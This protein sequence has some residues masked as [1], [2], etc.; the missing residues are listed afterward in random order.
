MA[1]KEVISELNKMASKVEGTERIAQVMFALCIVFICISCQ[2]AQQSGPS[3][4][5]YRAHGGC[6]F[7]YGEMFC[8]S[9]C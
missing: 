8:I 5:G 1:V 7:L 3:G 4:R 6:K 2:R 9:K